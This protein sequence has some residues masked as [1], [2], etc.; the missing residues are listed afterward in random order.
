M[1]LNSLILSSALSLF[2]TNV[3][4]DK[5]A[6]F[7]FGGAFGSTK[8]DFG[9]TEFDV[10]SELGLDSSS[11]KITDSSNSFKVFAGYKVNQYF[12]VEAGL[13]NY[14]TFGF[15][16]TFAGDMGWDVMLAGEVKAE[17]ELTATTLSLV[18][19]FPVSETFALYGKLGSA[20]WQADISSSSNILVTFNGASER[21]SGNE[22]DSE[23]DSDM[24]TAFGAKFQYLDVELFAEF[25]T[26][27]F[28]EEKL[29][30]INFGVL[31]Y[32]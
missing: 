32:F 8:I 25:E 16:Q 11:S 20:N 3:L 1:K 9:Q 26:I 23:S 28:E 6:D 2:A 14:G 18:G 19:M 15:E 5:N 29:D 17:M 7:Y 12:A 30:N 10:A 31:T 13:V 21:S 22:V 4:A 24:V 27:H